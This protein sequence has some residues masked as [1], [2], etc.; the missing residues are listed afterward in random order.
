MHGNDHLKVLHGR[1][2]NNQLQ[3]TEVMGIKITV[4][5]YNNQHIIQDSI[6]N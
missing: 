3:E 2:N 1:V 6:M 5:K 4:T